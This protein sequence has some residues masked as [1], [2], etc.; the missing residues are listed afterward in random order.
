MMGGRVVAARGEGV[1]L[2]ELVRVAETAGPPT[3]LIFGDWYPALR[4][5]ELRAGKTAK[6]MLLGVPVLVGRKND[7]KLFA[8]RDL[9]PHRGIPLSAGWFDGET[10]TCK[11]HGWRFEPC[12]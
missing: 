2:S 3:E 9:C 10:V 7:G 11:Y 6:A 4:T 1:G 8:M 5:S 12:S